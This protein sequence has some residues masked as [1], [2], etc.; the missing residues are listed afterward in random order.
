MAKL[1]VSSLRSDIEATRGCR[2]LGINKY[3]EWLD[4]FDFHILGLFFNTQE[5]AISHYLTWCE[6]QAQVDAK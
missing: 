5:E 2:N 6:Q 4:T 1:N 3:Q